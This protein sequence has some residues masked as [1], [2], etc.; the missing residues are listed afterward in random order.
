MIPRTPLRISKANRVQDLAF[1]QRQKTK[2]Q[3][4]RKP[5]TISILKESFQSLLAQERKRKEGS[6]FSAAGREVKPAKMQ[7]QA[8][9]ALD[10][11]ATGLGSKASATVLLL[12]LGR[13]ALF[14][15]APVSS[16]VES[17]IPSYHQRIKLYL[18]GCFGICKTGNICLQLSGR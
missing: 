12:S 8:L 3:T 4:Q 10:Q 9:G 14:L 16:P 13:V 7:G 1:R 11:R 6:L 17:K 18:Q 5:L 2:T 15:W